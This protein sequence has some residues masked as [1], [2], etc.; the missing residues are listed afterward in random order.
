VGQ[1][2]DK[3]IQQQTLHQRVLQKLEEQV[4]TEVAEKIAEAREA[5]IEK[6]GEVITRLENKENIQERLENNLQE[7][8]GSEFK[9]FKNLEILKE[10][11]EKVPEE[12][13]EAIRHA[14]ENTLRRLETKIEQLPQ[15]TL[16]RFKTYTETISGVKKRQVE[17]LEDLKE[18]LEEK[19]AVL[20]KIIESTEGIRE[21]IEVKERE[22]TEGN[23]GVCIQL[24]DPVCGK[25]GKT[26]SNSCFASLA[27]VEV[28]QK[29]TCP[30]S[31]QQIQSRVQTQT[32]T[33]TQTQSQVRT[34]LEEL[35]QQLKQLQGQ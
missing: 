4:P 28:S 21:R 26:Y 13:K 34:Q 27:G 20:E 12:A 9:D 11:E 23:T 22:R 32:E 2:L 10:L 24:W 25:D 6:F 14:K 30:S 31:G 17:I 18:K 3:F 19:P 5:Y 29:G 16:E 15:E 7:I 33:Q 8:K 35:Q 1:F